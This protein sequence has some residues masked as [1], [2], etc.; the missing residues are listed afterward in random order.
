VHA[1]AFKAADLTPSRI[2]VTNLNSRPAVIDLAE[3]ELRTDTATDA[4]TGAPFQVNGAEVEIP[5]FGITWISRK[6][7]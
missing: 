7:I 1:G 4:V 3:A 6:T 2:L 5:E